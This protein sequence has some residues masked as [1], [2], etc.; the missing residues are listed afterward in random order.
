M[1]VCMCMCSDCVYGGGVH[2]CV[3]VCVSLR[4]Q[5]S[6]RPWPCVRTRDAV[7]RADVSISSL[8]Y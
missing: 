2:H 1:C 7:F 4:P 8:R 3:R 6:E 5:G